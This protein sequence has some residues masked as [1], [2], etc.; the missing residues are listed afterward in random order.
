MKTQHRRSSHAKRKYQANFSVL[1]MLIVANS[2][3]PEDHAAEQIKITM[4]AFEALKSGHGTTKDYDRLARAINLCL[5]RAE[6]IDTLVVYAMK[7]AVSAMDSCSD[8]H[9]RHGRYG[10]TGIDL[11]SLEYA[12][13]YYAEIFRLSTPRQLMDADNIAFREMRKQMRAAA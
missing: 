10:F 5:V 2:P 6:S 3:M 7:A 12:L 4:D 1:S 9:A 8:I 11:Q 13:E